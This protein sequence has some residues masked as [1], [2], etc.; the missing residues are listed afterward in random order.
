MFISCTHI[1][2]EQPLHTWELI[3]FSHI[4]S[5]PFFFFP[6]KILLSPLANLHDLSLSLFPLSNESFEILPSNQWPLHPS[7]AN[8]NWEWFA[9]QLILGWEFFGPMRHKKYFI[10][11]SNRMTILMTNGIGGLILPLILD[12]LMRFLSLILILSIYW[13]SH[14]TSSS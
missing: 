1:F 14:L 2:H 9:L 12:I 3:F 6:H 10:L 7:R 5:P 8:E 11:Q 4:H 13:P